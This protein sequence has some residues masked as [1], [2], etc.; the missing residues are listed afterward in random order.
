[1]ARV[2][3]GKRA[4]NNDGDVKRYGLQALG[5]YEALCARA[6]QRT[7]FPGGGDRVE[8]MLKGDL[9]ALEFLDSLVRERKLL[10]RPGGRP[11][12]K[13][14]YC[15]V[16]EELFPLV[17]KMVPSGGEVLSFIDYTASRQLRQRDLLRQRLR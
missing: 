5:T 11:D 3:R 12:A 13:L 7:A 9:A 15:D 4:A 14:V 2:Y 1:M 10:A 6:K 17:A 8:K 16:V